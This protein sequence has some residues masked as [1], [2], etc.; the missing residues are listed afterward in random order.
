ML[1]DPEDPEIEHI[2][3]ELLRRVDNSNWPT[4]LCMALLAYL[5]KSVVQR[6]DAE[7]IRNRNELIRVARECHAE[8]FLMS[9][10]SYTVVQES[11]NEPVCLLETACTALRSA[12]N[13][14]DLIQV[15]AL[16]RTALTALERAGQF[17]AA[18]KILGLVPQFHGFGE[19][20]LLSPGFDQSRERVR[21]HLTEPDYDRLLA[22]GRSL[23]I[24]QAVELTEAALDA[25]AAP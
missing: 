18:A 7:A 1:S 6:Q 23:T 14:K 12:V 3:E 8:W 15:P 5:I 10:G 11:E 25:T 2:S 22:E 4:G 13:S 16:L 17:E 21:E 20:G 19:S 9:S 24:E